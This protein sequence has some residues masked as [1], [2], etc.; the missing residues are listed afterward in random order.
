MTC[1]WSSV[2]LIEQVLLWTLRLPTEMPRALAAVAVFCAMQVHAATFVV[3][4]DALVPIPQPAVSA[5]GHTSAGI[6]TNYE[7]KPCEFVGKAVSLSSEVSEPLDWVATTKNACSW[8][9]SAAPIWVLRRLDSGYRVVLFHVA[10][11]L[12]LGRETQNGLRH[13]ATARA[14]AARAESQ[15]WKFDGEE[16][17]CKSES[18][19]VSLLAN[20]SV[21]GTC[22]RQAPYVER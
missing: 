15:L 11:D 19:G 5:I 22:L 10:Y 18:L 1:L 2:Q 3:E 20:P 6:P 7:D 9:A 4:D 13:I 8:A 17:R 14:T 12:T 16:Y 21:K